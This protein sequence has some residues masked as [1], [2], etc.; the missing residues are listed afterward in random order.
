MLWHE[1]WPEHK[2]ECAAL[3][4]KDAAAP[5]RGKD[6]ETVQCVQCGK[7][8]GPFSKCSVGVRASS[9]P[10]PSGSL[11]FCVVIIDK[12]FAATCLVLCFSSLAG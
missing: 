3:R 12:K 1:H 2:K 9:C 8:E 11:L 5:S 10:V 4:A 6:A 7:M